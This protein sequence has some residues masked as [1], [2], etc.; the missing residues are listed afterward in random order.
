MKNVCICVLIILAMDSCNNNNMLI[1]PQGNEY[2]SVKIRDNST[3]VY[4][5]AFM[6]HFKTVSSH[7]YPKYNACSVRLIKDK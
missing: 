4:L 3:L 7:N 5:V 2:T 6:K 1:D